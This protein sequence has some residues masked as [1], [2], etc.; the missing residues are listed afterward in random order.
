M[1]ADIRQLKILFATHY[2]TFT[3]R[4]VHKIACV[5]NE[6]TETI[7]QWCQTPEWLVALEFWGERSGAK[8]NNFSSYLKRN[9]DKRL[10]DPRKGLKY[11]DLK[12]AERLWRELFSECALEDL[13]IQQDAHLALREASKSTASLLSESFLLCISEG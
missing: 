12:Q 11:G 9:P 1:S 5:V 7:Y 13:P 2:F 10:P 4:S 3:S 8:V 6:S